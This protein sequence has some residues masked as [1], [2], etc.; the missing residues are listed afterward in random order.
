MRKRSSSGG[1]S[2]SPQSFTFCGGGDI[3]SSCKTPS[4][5]KP[6]EIKTKI[7][8]SLS[9]NYSPSPTS[10]E[11]SKD[12][13]NI[14]QFSPDDII[15]I[16]KIASGGF[17]EVF[18]IQIHSTIYA[19]KRMLK[20]RS[21]IQRNVDKF[22]NELVKMNRIFQL[23]CSR[24]LKLV[25]YCFD[26]ENQ[27]YWI[28][29]EFINVGDLYSIIHCKEQTLKSH[30]YGLERI[31]NEYSKLIELIHNDM[32]VKIKLALDIAKCID[33][34]HSLTRYAHLDVKSLNILVDENLQ[35]R[36]GD[37][38]DAKLVD[39][40]REHYLTPFQPHG[41][42]Y[43]MA[44]EIVKQNVFCQKS[45]IYA[46]SIVF[47]ELLILGK[48][49]PGLNVLDVKE[50]LERPIISNPANNNN[51][52]NTNSDN[53]INNTDNIPYRMNII[54]IL[55]Q[56]GCDITNQCRNFISLIEDMWKE[57]VSERLSSKQVVERLSNLL[58]SDE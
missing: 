15:I 32:N 53:Q 51:T 11:L 4:I 58:E 37:W 46:L 43:W 52:D 40:S 31:R 33:E 47:T 6:L 50:K 30:H 14:K 20:S 41:T 3:E 48:P 44:P 21:Q 49:Y 25:G 27:N 36:V 35:I 26:K 42:I 38:C 10:D 7:K 24:V 1:G 23:G 22:A 19:G 55:E 56:K 9:Y 39:E 5:L 28:V 54:E 8:S 2:S 18:K 34:L 12:M 29:T 45:D 13:I 17:A 16:D 57:D